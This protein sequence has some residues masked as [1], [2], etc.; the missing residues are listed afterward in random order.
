M[1]REA[2]LEICQSETPDV[3]QM[4]VTGSD[5]LWGLCQQ[6]PLPSCDEHCPESGPSVS[7]ATGA[8]HTTSANPRFQQAR[9]TFSLWILHIDG[10]R[11]LCKCYSMSFFLLFTLPYKKNPKTKPHCNVP[12]THVVEREPVNIKHEY[13]RLLYYIIAKQE[14][15]LC[16]GECIFLEVTDRRLC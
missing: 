11:R 8:E 14:H 4:G 10:N 16:E 1:L 6:L 13:R 12:E 9:K 15:L 2:F 7:I 5:D 3:P